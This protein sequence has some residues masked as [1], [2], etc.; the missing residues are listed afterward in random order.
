MRGIQ[1]NIGVLL[2][3]SGIA[4]FIAAT[5]AVENGSSDR[6]GAAASLLLGDK[7]LDRPKEENPVSG[8]SEQ[9]MGQFADGDGMSPDIPENVDIQCDGTATVDRDANTLTFV[10]NPT[11]YMASDNKIEIYAHQAVVNS[12]E[13]TVTLTGDLS[14]YRDGSLTRAEKAVYNY[15]T[16]ELTTDGIKAKSN[17]M[18]L[19][20]GTFSYAKNDKG[21]DYLE[22]FDASVSS[23]D[24]QD[25]DTWIS[26]KRIRIYPQDRLNFSHL[27]FNYKNVPFFY[28]PY[29]SHSLNPREG[30]M[31]SL[32][33]RS[34]WGAF[35]LNRYGILSGNRRVEKGRPTADYLF[36]SHLDY[37]SR[38]GVAIGEDIVDLKL[39]QEASNMK[40]LSV[41]YAYDQDPS[42]SPTD[43]PRKGV[44]NNR[45]RIAL[46]QMWKL[47]LEEY[48]GA[49]WRAKANINVLSDQYMLRDFYQDLFEANS[50]PDNTLTLERT[51][52]QSVL[53]LLQRMPINDF[54][55]TDQRSE[56][57]YDR[58]RGSLMNS[59]FIYESQTSFALMRQVVPAEM[60]MTVR[61]RLEQLPQNDP[62]REFW[63]HMLQTD[64][65]LRFH[66]Y[67]ELSRSYKTAGFLNI[68]PRLGGG[69]TAYMDPTGDLGSFNQ[70]IFYAGLDTSFKISRKYNS[71]RWDALGLNTMNHIIQPYTTLMYMGVNE[72]DSPYP[73]IDG[74]ASTTNP[75][76]L[77]VG[78]MTEIDSLSTCSVLRYGV[79]NFLMTEQDNS[80][81]QWFS[82]D[83]FMD[84]YL[85]N[86]SSD[87][88]F[89][90]LY[91]M[92]RWS[93][94]PWFS[95]AS[96]VQ[97]PVLR[98]EKR[99]NYQEY[100]NSLWFQPFR[101][102]E[103]LCSHR[104]LTK[105]PLLED[106]NQLNLRVIYR[107]SEELALGG[108]WRWEMKRKDKR[109]EIQEYNIYKNM[110]SWYF[111]CGLF[112]R[113]NGGKDE[114]GIGF[115]FTLKE[116]GNYMPFTFN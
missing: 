41:Y 113:V 90:N 100:N 49:R 108:S 63:E 107:I 97:F 15:E 20:S 50:E 52:R 59:R 36:Q 84:A 96:V 112:M 72:L 43:E 88:K 25:P 116:T 111:G 23:E 114:L 55:I 58:I 82:W 29:F 1:R 14:I 21:E 18:L 47:S 10:G 79:R 91:S 87:K 32:G 11:V 75:M 102:T 69:Y 81:K 86:A 48:P 76:A 106:S 105:H 39:E 77:S 74:S 99:E 8:M 89:S 56:I 9:L 68:T 16:K 19:R 4:A 93:P 24:D 6:V 94:L 17:G 92:T 51:D 53:T 28:F 115:S 26:A 62:N 104:Y 27:T 7:S 71:V 64:G 13:K 54:Y 40:G 85:H 35:M 42:I 65:F 30:Y 12:T 31:P 46:Q 78:R 45:W 70:G 44:D 95:Y 33:A 38:R 83:A 61:D 34:Y 5:W 73:R 67:H 2:M 66:T 3:G 110:G 103:I 60:R 22:G 101:S 57:S 80:A 98:D 37:R 109:L